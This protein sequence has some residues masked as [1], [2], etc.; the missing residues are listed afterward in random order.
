MAEDFLTQGEDVR[1]A[2]RAHWRSGL[3]GIILT[4]VLG[5]GGLWLGIW[6]DS[7]VWGEGEGGFFWGGLIGLGIGLLVAIIGSA[8]GLVE[9][10]TTRYW[11]TNERL[12]VRTGWLTKSGKEIPVDAINSVTVKQ[13]PLERALG[14]GDMTVESAGKDSLQVFRNVPDPTSVQKAIYDAREDRTMYLSGAGGR[15][16]APPG[17]GR[18]DDL[19]DLAKLRDSGAISEAEFEAEKAKL[20]G[21]GDGGAEA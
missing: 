6:I 5:I 14:Y 9:W 11:V 2:F 21:D 15:E 19:A 17:R 7:S 12:I 16:A 1:M 8:G 3:V 10:L 18:Y 20:L 4:V 13:G